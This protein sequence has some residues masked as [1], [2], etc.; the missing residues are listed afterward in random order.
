VTK[1][2]VQRVAKQYLIEDARTVGILV[3]VKK[4]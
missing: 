2:D 3:P 4:P 1:E